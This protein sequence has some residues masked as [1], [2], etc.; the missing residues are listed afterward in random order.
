MT[1]MHFFF[2]EISIWFGWHRLN[3]GGF[4]AKKMR[5]FKEKVSVDYA[6]SGIGLMHY[7]SSNKWLLS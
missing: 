5:D 4:E 1:I 7:G 3:S 6:S 2:L